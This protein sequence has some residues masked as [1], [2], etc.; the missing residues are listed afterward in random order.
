[1]PYAEPKPPY[2]HRRYDVPATILQGT[3]VLN[4]TQPEA[5]VT[6]AVY[7]SISAARFTA[8]STP[9]GSLNFWGQILRLAEVEH[10]DVN[11]FPSDH[12]ETFTRIAELLTNR[13]IQKGDNQPVYEF[14]LQP[15]L[16]EDYVVRIGLMKLFDNEDLTLVGNEIIVPIGDYIDTPT[17][18]HAYLDYR[19]WETTRDDQSIPHK[20]T[21]KYL[22]SAI[23]LDGIRKVFSEE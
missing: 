18:L 2:I 17:I 4:R 19:Q 12:T 1:M 16:D 23:A 10:K 20:V 7:R 11:R 5:P 15:E 14:A 13:T 22:A 21:A 8:Q 3:S 6:A 9:Q